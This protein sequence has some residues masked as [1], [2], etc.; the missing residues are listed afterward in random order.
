ML[1]EFI[2]DGVSRLIADGILPEHLD[3]D[4]LAEPAGATGDQHAGAGS[5]GYQ[6]VKREQVGVWDC[7]SHSWL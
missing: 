4:W 1:Y 6:E 2:T 5:E 7:C 3:D